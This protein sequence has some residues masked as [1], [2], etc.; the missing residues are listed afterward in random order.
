MPEIF[1]KKF[2]VNYV[3][4]GHSNASNTLELIDNKLELSIEYGVFDTKICKQEI[5]PSKKEWIQFWG[6]MDKIG[7]WNWKKEYTFDSK[8][9]NADGDIIKIKIDL[10]DKNLDTFCWCNA[11][12]GLAEFFDALKR[13]IIIDI[14]NPN[15]LN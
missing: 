6:E 5:I 9:I 10:E 15:A 12:E 11:P 7:I 1:P 14:R 13:L 4:F 3:F 2:I 8:E